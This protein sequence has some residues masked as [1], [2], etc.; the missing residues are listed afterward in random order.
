MRR[1]S[2]NAIEIDPYDP[3]YC[4]SDKKVRFCCRLTGDNG[5]IARSSP[6]S[7][8]PP[9]PQTGLANPRCY[10]RALND[11]STEMSGEHLFSEVTLNLLTGPDGKIVR[12]GYPWQE[13]GE[14]QLLTPSTCKANVLCKRHNNAL[15]SVDATAG[16]F[17]KAIL[18]T[19][20]SL[21]GHEMRVL[22]LSG[23]DLERWMLKTLC[24]HIVVVRKFGDNWEPPVP[25]LDILWGMK[26]FPS[27]CG[28]YF[29]QSIGETSPD[30]P[31]LGLRVMTCPG[32]V[33]PT[34]TN[35][36]LGPHRFAL[37][38]IAPTAQQAPGSA[39]QTQYYRP[40]DFVI[41]FGKSEVVYIFGWAD[42]VSPR[43]IGMSWAPNA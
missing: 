19:P 41:N 12:A 43:R 33:G 2:N 4:G 40:T 8:T 38:M 23:D 37:A 25:W 35:I 29:N 39:L 1:L 11:C 13:E 14:V 42:S 5:K 31:R 27:G 34:G 10:A 20:D 16:R 17:L 3:C 9:G 6:S 28:L 15:S 30:A 32:T 26:P 36:Q 24:T 7:C 18:R 21:R 22:M